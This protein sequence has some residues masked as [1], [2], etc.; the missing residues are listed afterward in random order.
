MGKPGFAVVAA[1]AVLCVAAVG[2]ASLA[3]TGKPSS[4]VKPGTDRY[5]CFDPTFTR[6]FQT[7]DDHTIIVESDDNQAYELSMAGPCFGLDN[8]FA[9]GIRSRTGM[10]EVCD[11][12][13]ADIVFH[14]NGF[15]ERRE[16]RVMSIR[17]LTGDE[18]AK[19]ITPPKSA[20]HSSSASGSASSSSAQ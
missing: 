3:M 19:Y 17:H 2:G 6:G 10:H 13:D 15:G 11:P 20:A 14:D 4:D 12:F 9:I 5:R 18:A 16:C 1:V 7:P 8:S